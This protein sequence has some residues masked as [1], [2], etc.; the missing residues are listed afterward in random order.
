MPHMINPRHLSIH[1]VSRSEEDRCTTG[2]M[3]PW[4][5]HHLSPTE[6]HRL[7]VLQLL[8]G[9]EQHRAH[10]TAQERPNVPPYHLC[11]I[12][13]LIELYISSPLLVISSD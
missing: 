8:D 5:S 13:V 9:N 1:Q 3:A 12:N 6:Q 4:A 10:D 11:V 7:Y 2:S